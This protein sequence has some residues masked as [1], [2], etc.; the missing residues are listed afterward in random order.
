MARLSGT[1][2]GIS[3][4]IIVNYLPGAAKAPTY[5]QLPLSFE[6]NRGQ[7]DADVLYLA[8]GSQQ[9]VL[10]KQRSAELHFA[11]EVLQVN[12]IGGSPSAAVH[13]RDRQAGVS[14]YYPDADRKRWLTGIPNFG[15]VEYPGIF[16]G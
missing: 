13:A 12:F 8:R 3:L 9:T 15:A 5:G 14:N 4:F 1:L 10:I 6:P 16:P 11:G 7:T 2:F